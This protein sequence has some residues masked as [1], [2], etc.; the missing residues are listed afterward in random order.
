M[1]GKAIKISRALINNQKHSINF[2]KTIIKEE[3]G[4]NFA[5]EKAPLRKCYRASG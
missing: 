3:S 5:N 2:E 1:N 4:V